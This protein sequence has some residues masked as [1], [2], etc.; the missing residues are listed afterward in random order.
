[1]RRRLVVVVALVLAV[2]G[3][4][5]LRVVREGRAAL[6]EGDEALAAKRPGDAVAA[7]ES[8]ARWYL[9]FA[10]HVDEAYDRLRSFARERKSL[11]AWRAIRSAA[12]ATRSLWT[13]HDDDLAE[14]NA[15]IAELSAAD[16]DGAPVLG[17]DVG[18]RRAWHAG[19]LAADPRPSDAA[20]ALALFGVAAWLAG[21]AVLVARA[22]DDRGKLVRRPALVGFALTLGGIL[23]WAVGLYSA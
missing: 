11:P 8:A 5:A 23:A 3:V 13:P 2:L 17:D 15:Q 10:P 18:L 12:L 16:P 7:W 4:L 19:R 14:A 20:S 6:A 21:I 9:P 22:L 1:M